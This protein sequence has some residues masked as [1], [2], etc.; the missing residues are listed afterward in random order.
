MR[1]RR[2]IDRCYRQRYAFRATSPVRLL[3]P[4][5]TNAENGDLLKVASRAR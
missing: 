1:P 3:M 2:E 5:Q 4:L